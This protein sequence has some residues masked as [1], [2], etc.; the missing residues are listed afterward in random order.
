MVLGSG[1]E[2]RHDPRIGKAWPHMRLSQ[3][4][5]VSRPFGFHAEMLDD[6]LLSARRR[7]AANG[8][9]GSLVCRADVFLQILEGPRAAVTETFG[10]ILRDDRHVEVVILHCGDTPDR[11]FPS[12]TMRDDPPHSWMWPREEVREGAV[13]ETTAAHAMAIFRRL[14]RLPR[15]A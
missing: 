7:N 5:Y 8:I 10:R 12:W 1:L 3:L 15:A 14:S 13:A 9:T 2:S 6:V 11:M 4:I